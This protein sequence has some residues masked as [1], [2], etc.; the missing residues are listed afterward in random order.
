MRRPIFHSREAD[1]LAGVVHPE[2]AALLSAERAE[3]RHALVGMH[4]GVK[5]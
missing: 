1:D 4:E 5:R 3:I 2:R